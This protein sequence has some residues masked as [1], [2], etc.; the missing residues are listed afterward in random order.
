MSRRRRNT[1]VMVNE[2]SNR[3]ASARP[4][5]GFQGSLPEVPGLSITAREAVSCAI[6]HQYS[7]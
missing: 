7:L 2:L 4:R 1:Q 5:R 3:L 6:S